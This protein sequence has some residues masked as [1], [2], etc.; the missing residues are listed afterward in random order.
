MSEFYYSRDDKWF[1][2]VSATELKQLAA[3]GAIQGNDLIAKD[4]IADPTPA[5]NVK[6][7]FFLQSLLSCRDRVMRMSYQKT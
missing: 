5:R 2:P 3:S 1:G 4:G 6:R 7:P